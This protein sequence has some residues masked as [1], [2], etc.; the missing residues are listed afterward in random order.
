MRQ[1][2]EEES[3][4]ERRKTAAQPTKGQPQAGLAPW[5]EVI[6]PHADVASGRFEQAEFAADLLRSRVGNRR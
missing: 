1:M 6:T 4:S 3:R 5:R 2:F